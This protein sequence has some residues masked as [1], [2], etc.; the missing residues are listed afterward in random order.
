MDRISLA[1]CAIP[2]GEN[3]ITSL[4]LV[5]NELATNA[6]KYGA[7][8]TSEGRLEIDIRETGGVIAM[9]WCE[10]GGQPPDES[11]SGFGCDLIKAALRG[12]RGAMR[13]E[14]D[15]QSLTTS[16]EFD[17]AALAC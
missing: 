3:A 1:P 16:L 9:R 7:F 6:A 17:R 11:R 4:A 2:V 13:R 10:R 8:A 5:L 14:W 15:G 12:L